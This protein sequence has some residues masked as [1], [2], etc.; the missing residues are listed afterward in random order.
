MRNKPVSSNNLLLHIAQLLKTNVLLHGLL[1]QWFKI[2][3][4][5]RCY[6]ST[7]T[8]FRSVPFTFVFLEI[9]TI[10]G[11]SVFASPISQWWK[12]DDKAEAEQKIVL[13][14]Y[15]W[16]N[17]YASM[18]S[19]RMRTARLLTVSGGGL[20]PGVEG[21][22]HPGGVGSAS[23]KEPASRERRVCIQGGLYLPCEQNDRQV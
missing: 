6:I 4:D 10:T 9:N 8:D 11:E 12:L 20:H 13:D 17:K 21:G 15:Y 1:S 19:S 2:F 18:H 5:F 23:R 14:K 3:W 22:L 16:C 7:S